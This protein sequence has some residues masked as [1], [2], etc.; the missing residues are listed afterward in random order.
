MDTTTQRNAAL[1]EDAA[2]AAQALR[3]QTI[4][5]TGV[6]GVCRLD[7]GAASGRRRG[8]RRRIHAPAGD[9]SDQRLFCDNPA[10]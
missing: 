6:V 9:V 7:R 10:Q 4:A 1:V 2:A 5:L 3:E 8:G